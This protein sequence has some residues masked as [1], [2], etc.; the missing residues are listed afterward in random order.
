[1]RKAR[2]CTGFSGQ[3]IFVFVSLAAVLDGRKLKC[4]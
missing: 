3:G 4:D 2:Y 1:M